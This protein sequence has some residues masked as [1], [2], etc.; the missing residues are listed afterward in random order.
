MP[1]HA[2]R[3][4]LLQLPCAI[5][6]TGYCS[7]NKSWQQLQ[8]QR[9][10]KTTHGRQLANRVVTVVD[11][12]N[13]CALRGQPCSTTTKFSISGRNLQNQIGRYNE[14]LGE[15]RPCTSQVNDVNN[16]SEPQ[17]F[18]VALVK[19]HGLKFRMCTSVACDNC[20]AV[21]SAAGY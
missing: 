16:L 20:T 3:D 13:H 9:N 8:L 15:P 21:I 2:P 12:A 18:C 19:S 1:A 7:C 6:A 14:N 17:Y 4:L 10:Y 11:L 5:N